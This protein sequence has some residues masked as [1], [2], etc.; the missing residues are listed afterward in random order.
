[1]TNI[2]IGKHTMRGLAFTTAIISTVVLTMAPNSAKAG[3]GTGGA[4]ALGLGAFA[5]GSALSAAP[6]Y[7]YYGSPYGYYYPPAYSYPPVPYP[8][9]YSYPYYYSYPYSR[10]YYYAPY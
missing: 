9:Q 10:P 4:V 3:I 1:M 2:I 7:G 6:Y 8:S 5:L